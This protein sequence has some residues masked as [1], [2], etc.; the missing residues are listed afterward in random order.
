MGP[1]GVLQEIVQLIGKDSLDE[2]GKV[3]LDVAK[4]IREDFL[5]QN[6]FT[7]YDRYCPLWK[8]IAM[9]KNIV[10]YHDL[11][12]KAVTVGMGVSSSTQSAL[13]ETERKASLMSIKQH[14]AP[15][16]A[17]LSMQKMRDVSN[18]HEE[19]ENKQYFKDIHDEII[20]AFSTLTY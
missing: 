6:S 10:T 13:G 18:V 8:T 7:P 9:I 12:Q 19:E 11:A 14:M 4:M 5:Q 2:A 16:L 3:T 15:T 17:K 1:A 20:A